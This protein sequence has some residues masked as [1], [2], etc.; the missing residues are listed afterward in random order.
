MMPETRNFNQSFQINNM[1]YLRIANDGI[2]DIRLVALM[3]GTTKANDIF[4]IG[5]FG[6]GLKYTLA[7]LFR[8]NLHFRIFAGMDEISITLDEEVIREETFEIIC[9]NGHRT[10]ITTRMGADWEAWMI[11]R[12]LWSNALDEGG[13][14]RSVTMNT[15]GEAGKTV[16]YIQI[17]KHIQAV[18]DEWQKYF[19]HG[20]E[21]WFESHSFAIYPGGKGRRI[22]KNGILIDEN[23]DVNA[24]FAYDIKYASLNEL[25]EF[26]GSHEYEI[27][28][29]L[30]DANDRVIE[31]FL[32]NLTEEF[33]EGKELSFDWWHKFSASWERV[34]GNAKIIHPKALEHLKESG[35][36]IPSNLL[37]VPELLYKALAKQSERVSALRIA[38]KIGEFFEDHSVEAESKLKQGLVILE[39]C[40]YHVHPELTFV[41]GYFGDKRI[42]GKVS[43][44]EKKVYISNTVLQASLHSVV[45]T[46]LEES[47]HFATG[48]T[49]CSREFQQHFIN[50]YTREL[51]SKHKIEV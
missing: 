39:A 43:M 10:S 5:Q 44:N 23:K 7:F 22:Y 19:L 51:L 47:E 41:F 8:K 3:G 25:R 1:K 20:I 9:I 30:V 16:F 31:Y 13:A 11:I 15:Y 14:D 32:E 42:L 49:D 27:T 40:G 28:S 46:L 48:M 26:K 36:E 17:D 38:D 33:Y 45:A 6:T 50:L 21:P 12:E 35:A 34:I 4:K 2:L 24:M 18:L 37:V 29:A